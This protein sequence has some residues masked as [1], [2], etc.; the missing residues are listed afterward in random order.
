MSEAAAFG[1]P[2]ERPGEIPSVN[3]FPRYSPDEMERR[4]RWVAEMM[5]DQELDSVLVGGPTAALETSVQYFSNWPPQVMSYLT[6]LPGEAPRL[7]VRLW[8]HLPDARRIA[9]VDDVVYGGDTP[10]DQAA[11][12]ADHLAAQGC[13]RLGLIGAV[14]HADYDRLRTGLA[15][16]R[17]VDLNPAYQRFRLVKSAEEMVFT[18]VASR[19]NDAAV[20]ALAAELGPGM[21]EHHVAKIVEDVYLAHRGVNLIHF[22]LSTS[23]Q[24]PHIPV[25][26]QYHPDRV[27]EAGDV[28]VTEISTTFW[29]YA[30]QILRT[31]TIAAEPTP[32]YARLHQV[33]S[34]VYGAIVSRLRP[35][36]TVGEILDESDA[37]AHAGFDIWDDLV[38]GFGGAY[39]PPVIR[40]RAAR[41]AT[42]PDDFAYPEGALIVVQPNVIDGDAGVQLGNSVW[43]TPDGPEVTQSYPVELIR[44]G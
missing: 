31:F 23:M 12:V 38:H 4:H 36:V 35:G 32:R 41:G 14:P 30:G 24:A 3:G 5:A 10:A 20:A 21:P 18:R 29:G 7:A 2:Y 44:V 34:E 40:T 17:F 33:A 28:L 15:E 43:I 19:M 8:N 37:I 13:R 16:A 6:F 39:L 9:A 27:I 26:H 25:P 22:S 42:H 11:A 1:P